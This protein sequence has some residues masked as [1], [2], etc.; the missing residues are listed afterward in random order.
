M[1]SG[2]WTAQ[3]MLLLHEILLPDHFCSRCSTTFI[4]R[5]VSTCWPPP[6]RCRPRTPSSSFQETGSLWSSIL[7]LLLLFCLKV[8][9][10]QFFTPSIWVPKA[11]MS[12]SWCCRSRKASKIFIT[13][14][15]FHAIFV[16]WDVSKISRVRYP[17][18]S[19]SCFW[20][21]P[22]F[23]ILSTNLMVFQSNTFGL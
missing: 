17:P 3:P 6:T 1:N 20:H 15:T 13:S 5:A 10:T 11:H 23:F 22:I 14:K 4:R 16:L 2:L 19:L 8:P 7:K 18:L 9:W 21:F 12:G